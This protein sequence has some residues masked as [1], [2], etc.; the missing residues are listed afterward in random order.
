MSGLGYNLLGL[1]VSRSKNTTTA[2]LNH[3]TQSL[4]QG[5]AQSGIQMATSPYCIYTKA[6]LDGS[7][8]HPSIEYSEH[9]ICKAGV[10][11]TLPVLGRYDVSQP[12]S[13]NSLSW[14]RTKMLHWHC[15]RFTVS[16]R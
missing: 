8:N 4:L 13:W 16:C 12:V 5:K 6:I 2:F 1:W 3:L 10:R 9:G 15:H 11:L 14:K 7:Q